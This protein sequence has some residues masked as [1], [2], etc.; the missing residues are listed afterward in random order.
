MPLWVWGPACT[1]LPSSTHS[2][3]LSFLERRRAR[4]AR[5]CRMWE[6]AIWK[7]LTITIWGYCGEFLFHCLRLR[8]PDGMLC[9]ALGV[10]IG[11]FCPS[12]T[13]VFLDNIFETQYPAPVKLSLM[14]I[15]WFYNTWLHKMILCQPHRMG[16]RQNP[17]IYKKGNGFSMIRP[18]MEAP[19]VR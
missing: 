19:Y 13:F 18:T 8:Q 10:N 2:C 4:S 16:H 1:A 17:N 12:A 9:Y 3:A 14:V 6:L 5:E 15:I 7:T 11:S